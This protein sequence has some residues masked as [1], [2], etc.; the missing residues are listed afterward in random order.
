MM[1]TEKSLGT[2]ESNVKEFCY[3]VVPRHLLI[4]SGIWHV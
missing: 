4:E 3:E 2:V 1:I